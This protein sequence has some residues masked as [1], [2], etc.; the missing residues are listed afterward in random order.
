[1]KSILGILMMVAIAGAAAAQAKGVMPKPAPHDT[2]QME[3]RALDRDA[4]RL[5]IHKRQM[6]LEEKAHRYAMEREQLPENF[7]EESRE[8][9]FPYRHWGMRPYDFEMR[10][11]M[12]IR[13]CMTVCGLILLINILLTILVSIDMAGLGRFNGLWIPVVLVV[14]IPGTAIYALFRIGD[15]VRAASISGK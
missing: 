3:E 2:M 10:H 7:R 12:F 4:E 5:D 15:F 8:M 11:W 13:F 9:G 6:E 14:G 1:M